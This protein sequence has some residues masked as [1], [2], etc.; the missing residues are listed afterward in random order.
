MDSTT[1]RNVALLSIHP[2]FVDRIFDGSK[3]IELRRINLPLELKHV[4]VYATSPVMRVVG[5][6]DV[7]DIV[8]DT[9]LNIWDT[10][11]DTSGIDEERYFQYFESRETA[12]G[13]R[14]KKVHPLPKPR[15]LSCLSRN[16]TPPQSIQ[17]LPWSALVKL[18]R[19]IADEPAQILFRR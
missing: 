7:Q 2:E 5:F 1:T 8:R 11:G 6:F 17:Y 10:Y 3:T 16:L 14:I 9:P 18:R 4:V 13:I 15:K 19:I 12:I